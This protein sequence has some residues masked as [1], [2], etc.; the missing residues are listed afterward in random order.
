MVDLHTQIVEQPQELLDVIARS[1]ES[2]ARAPGMQ[3]ICAQYMGQI[4]L[5]ENVK[6][7]EIGCGNGAATKLIMKHMNPAEL[8]GV[9]LAPTFIDMA[10]KALAD[11]PRASFTVGDAVQTGQIDAAFDLVIAHTVYSHLLDPEGALAEAYR[12][13]KPGGQMVIFDGDYAETVER[14]GGSPFDTA[15]GAVFSNMLHAPYIMRRLPELAAKAGFIVEA[16]QPHRYVQTTH[17]DFMLMLLSRGLNAA[18]RAG[19]ISNVLMDRLNREA[20]K[21][22]TNGTLSSVMLFLSLTAR[23]PEMI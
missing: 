5:P 11:E 18:A 2:R 13:L 23:K 15:V 8:I 10:K 12:V 1:M 20:Q 17:A 21:R 4:Q 16:L 6:V 7:L 14:F 3:Q 19:T 9:D 22:V